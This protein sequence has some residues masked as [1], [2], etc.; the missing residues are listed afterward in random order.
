[1]PNRVDLVPFWLPQMECVF[2]LHPSCCLR[3]YPVFVH[4]TDIRKPATQKA[5][6]QRPITSHSNTNSGTPSESRSTDLNQY[7]EPVSDD[8]DDEGN[9]LVATTNDEAAWADVDPQAAAEARA[10][11]EGQ[12]KLAQ[13]PGGRVEQSHLNAAQ[14]KPSRHE[15]FPKLTPQNLTKL[16]D[17][18]YELERNREL[19]AGDILEA[20]AGANPSGISL[21]PGRVEY[22]SSFRA[23]PGKRIAVPVRVEPKVFFACERTGSSSSSSSFELS[24]IQPL[25]VALHWIEFSVVVSAIGVGL[26]SFSDPHG[27]SFA[28]LLSTSP[29]KRRN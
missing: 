24:L 13:G 15:V 7:T 17:S 20:E 9:R 18:R 22:V 1:M 10:Y 21:V 25:L 28:H 27:T 3:A 4:R 2:P 8:E 11:R 29:R 5:Q 26:L 23:I 12:A 19:N 14:P 6:I 16:L